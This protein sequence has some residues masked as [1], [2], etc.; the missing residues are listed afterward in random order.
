VQYVYYDD[1]IALWRKG[2]RDGCFV[3]DKALTPVGFNGIE[4][5]DWENVRTLCPGE[6]STTTDD[7]IIQYVIYYDGITLWRKGV[8]D[9]CFVWDRAI[10]LTGFD[11]VEDTD[12]ENVRML[13]GV[14]TTTTES[15]GLGLGLLYN[16]YAATD[17]RN[18]ANT[19]WRV[20]TTSD[21]LTLML[22]LDPDGVSNNNTAGG[23]LKVVGTTYWDTPN[24]G[25]TNSTLFNGRGAGIRVG[26]TGAYAQIKSYLH[27]WNSTEYSSLFANRSSLYYNHNMLETTDGISGTQGNKH[28]GYAIRLIKET[29]TLTNGQTGTY[30]GNDGKTYRTICIGTQEW[31]ADNLCETLYRNGDLIPEVTDN[32]AWAALAKGARCS[33]NNDESNAHA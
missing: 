8:R 16:W 12:W 20:P 21:F 27:L 30:T 18:I 29:T 11:G 23:A 13:C 3:W 31:L 19:G 4:D 24:T 32:A 9:G 6:S 28:N 33:Y 2:V 26:S 10:T 7:G 14:G 5:T 25:A 22:Y 15:P 17:A 1:G